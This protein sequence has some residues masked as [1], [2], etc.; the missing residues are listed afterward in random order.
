MALVKAHPMPLG[1]HQP[2]QLELGIKGLFL[3]HRWVCDETHLRPIKDK[4]MRESKD[5]NTS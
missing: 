5:L 3:H 1:E 4:L 2:F